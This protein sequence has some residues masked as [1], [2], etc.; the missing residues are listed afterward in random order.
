MKRPELCFVICLAVAMTARLLV[1][2]YIGHSTTSGAEWGIAG[3]L[4][5]GN[6]VLSANREVDLHAASRV[7]DTEGTDGH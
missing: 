4:L 5:G 7:S 6:L 2:W 3:F 1:D